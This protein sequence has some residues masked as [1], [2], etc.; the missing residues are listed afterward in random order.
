[1]TQNLTLPPGYHIKFTHYRVITMSDGSPVTMA[2]YRRGVSKWHARNAGPYPRGGATIATIYNLDGE[3]VA[4]G[5]SDCSMLDAFSY[6]IGMAISSGRAL[7]KLAEKLQTTGEKSREVLPR[8]TFESLEE[9]RNLV[10]GDTITTDAHPME[11]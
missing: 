5:V 9:Y 1:M 3:E 7:K 2:L 8:G 6:K 4:V 11:A 10:M